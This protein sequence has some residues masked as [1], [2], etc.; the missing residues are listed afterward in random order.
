MYDRR[1][2]LHLAHAFADGDILMLQVKV[3]VHAAA[4]HFNGDRNRRGAA[5][6]LHE[7]IVIRHI[8]RQIMGQL[9][10]RLAL[11]L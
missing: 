9:G 8:A 1:Y 7:H 11:G 2:R 4:H 3:T 5:Q 10:Q 6:R